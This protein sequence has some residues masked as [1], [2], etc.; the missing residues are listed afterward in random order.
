MCISTVHYN[1]VTGWRRRTANHAAVRRHG[2]GRS[3]APPVSRTAWSH[4]VKRGSWLSLQ[5]LRQRSDY[6]QNRAHN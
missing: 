4:F 5:S 3:A 1:F 6:S 2:S